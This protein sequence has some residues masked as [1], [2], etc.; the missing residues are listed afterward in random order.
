MVKLGFEPRSASMICAL[1]YMEHYVIVSGLKI[2]EINGLSVTDTMTDPST[3]PS[4]F[5]IPASTTRVQKDYLLSQNPL[6]FWPV[7][8]RQRPTGT[9]VGMAL[10]SLIKR[11]KVEDAP[12]PY[13]LSM[14]VDVMPGIMAT[15]L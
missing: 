2:L 1:N 11:A 5:S 7:R 14:E 8:W 4:L 9:T 15:S 3:I 10:L 12:V 13:I 6:K